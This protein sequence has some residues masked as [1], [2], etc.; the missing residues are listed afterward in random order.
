LDQRLLAGV[1]LVHVDADR[2]RDVEVALG[3]QSCSE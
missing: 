2:P 3:V 1:V